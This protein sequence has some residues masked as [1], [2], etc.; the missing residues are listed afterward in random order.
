MS[1]SKKPPTEESQIILNALQQAVTA[2]LEKKSKLG[3]YA[4]IWDGNKPVVIGEDSKNN[5]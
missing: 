4:V 2:A 1:V 5:T 3:Q